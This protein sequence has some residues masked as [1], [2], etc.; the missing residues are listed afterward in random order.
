MI[1]KE[2]AVTIIQNMTNDLLQQQRAKGAQPAWNQLF[3]SIMLTKCVLEVV[4]KE[5]DEK[6]LRKDLGLVFEAGC[7]G[8][9]SQF[10]QRLEKAKLVDKATDV[11]E[12][13]V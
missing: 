4:S 6:Q 13:Y 7:A 3:H 12:E 5:K 8:N 9:C 10:R 2:V 1:T 11:V